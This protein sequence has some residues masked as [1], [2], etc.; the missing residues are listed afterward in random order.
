MRSV[1]IFLFFFLLTA[2]YSQDVPTI[3]ANRPRLDISAERFNWLKANISGGESGETYSRFKSSYDRNWVTDAD[4]YLVGSDSSQWHY[5]FNSNSAFQMSKMTAFLLQLGTDG[6]AQKRCE[7]IISRYIEYLEGLNFNNYSGDTK[8]NLLRINCDYGGILLDWTYDEIPQALRQDLSKALYRVLEYFMENYVLTPSGNSYVSSH[9]I[10]NCSITMHATLALHGADGLSSSQ[11]STINAWYKTLVD[12]WEN[13]ILPAFAYFRDDDGGWNWGAAYSMFGLP[14]QYQLFDD[15][16]YATD[17]NYYQDQPWVRESINQYWYFYRPDHFTIH[18]GD[19]IIHLDQ[20]N[21]VMYR[22]AAQFGDPRSQYLVQIYGGVGYLNNSSLIFQKLLYKDFEAANVQHPQP[23]L[24][25]WAN[26]TGLAVSRTSWEDDAT[27]LWFY[28]APSKRADH[29]H[30]DNNTF[31]IIRDKPLILDAGFYDSFGTSHYNNYY[32]RTIAHNSVCVY[33]A[34]ETYRNFGKTVSNDGGQI[35]SD[36]LE[37]LNDV[38]SDDHKRGKWIRYA[39]GEDYSYQVADAADSYQA[40]KLDRFER[41]VLFHKPDRVLVLDHIHL[42]YTQSNERKAKYINHFVNRPEIS[43]KI[44]NTQVADHILTYN[45]RDYKTTNGKGSLAIRTLL[46]ESTTTTLI[47]GSNYEYWVDGTNYPPDRNIDLV[48]EHPG[49]WRIEVEPTNVQENL[50]FLHTIKIGDNKNPASSGGKLISNANTIGVDWEN[51]LYLFQAQGDTASM[52]Y[53]AN[54]VAGDRVLKIF[55]LDLKS[56]S[57]FGV[58]VDDTLQRV[59]DA[60]KNGV[61]EIT[62]DLSSGNHKLVLK[63]TIAADP[64]PGTDPEPSPEE[65]NKESGSVLVYPNPTNGIFTVSIDEDTVSEFELSIYDSNG[66]KI[67]EHHQNSNQANIDLTAL[68]A[69]IY[70]LIIQYLNKT[71]KKKIVLI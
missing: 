31:T 35:E 59:G 10:Y 44:I 11:M 33:D 71:I 22:H 23:P 42:L 70:L 20:A 4:T 5:N 26:K 2:C 14:R 19:A 43:G 8:E 9:N 46:P 49:F 50:T 65:G 39:S 69:G 52:S 45:G 21:R 66:R 17:K 34:S 3:H 15:M 55:A 32:S 7:F 16:L 67:S 37:N 25:W 64:N 38:F 1:F 60:N 51:H 27:M 24:N 13:G 30:R 68:S 18:L 36:R 63:D 61:F 62:V 28:C 6:L 58:F 57:S 48:N 56:N 53:T 47:G 41:R 40:D 12:K 29:E 54:P